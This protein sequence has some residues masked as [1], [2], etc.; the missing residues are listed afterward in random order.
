[1]F[2]H[3]SWKP[4]YLGSKGQKVKSQGHEAEKTVP[5]IAVNALAFGVQKLSSRGSLFRCRMHI[6]IP[7][8]IHFAQRYP[9]DRIYHAPDTFWGDTIFCD[10]DVGVCSLESAGFFYSSLSYRIVLI[11]RLLLVVI[12]VGQ[13][14]E[15]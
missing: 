3:E 8:L 14:N 6:F 5:T 15:G 12:P 13:S 4:I 9:P 1:M 10:T 11:L 2:R 7:R